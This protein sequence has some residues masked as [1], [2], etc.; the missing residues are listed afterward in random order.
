M[1]PSGIDHHGGALHHVIAGEKHSGLLQHVADMIG[2]MAWRMDR[3]QRNL[4]Q[5]YALTVL[6]HDVGFERRVLT[7][8]R[9]AA[10]HLCARLGLQQRRRGG[11]VEMS[12]RTQ[13]ELQLLDL[14]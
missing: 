13:N 9:W 3:A 6:E 12:M 5:L 4:T 10:E 11:V 8:R 1:S 2:R 7:C 14:Q